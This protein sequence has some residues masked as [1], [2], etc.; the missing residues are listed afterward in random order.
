MLCI[1]ILAPI[2]I[3]NNLPWKIGYRLGKEA[4]DIEEI[5]N[6]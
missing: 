1:N 5:I 3:V 2:Y 6:S 4:L